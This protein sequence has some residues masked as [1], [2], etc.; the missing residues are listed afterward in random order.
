MSPHPVTWDGETWRTTEALFQ[1]LRFHVGSG[2][3]EEIR[4]EKSPMSA[5]LKAKT[6]KDQMVIVPCSVS[7]LQNMVNVLKLKLETHDEVERCLRET[8]SAFVVE[9]CTK[10]QRGSGLYWGAALQDGHWVGQ[11][12]LGQIWMNLRSRQL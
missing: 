1:A 4:A 10:R 2:I 5:K 6:Y 8:G 12:V 9:D 11:N 3:R 7:D